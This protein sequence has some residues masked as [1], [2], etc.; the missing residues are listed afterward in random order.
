MHSAIVALIALS[1]ACQ[2]QAAGKWTYQCPCSCDI[3]DYGRKRI[4]CDES[5]ENLISGIPSDSMDPKAQV[6]Y[7]LFL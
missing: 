2:V 4:V 3:D 5:Q 1:V 7:T 6:S